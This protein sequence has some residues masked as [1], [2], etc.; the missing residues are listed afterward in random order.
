MT[1]LD[2]R[3]AAIARMVRPGARTA[4]IGT[5]HGYLIAYLAKENIIPGGFAC[6][7]RPQPL[8]KARGL[9]RGQGL[10]SRVKVLLT[11]GLSGLPRDGVDD[12]VIAGMGGDTMIHI[13]S[14][15]G[16]KDP[17][18]R[19]LL[20][21]M[22]RASQLRQYLCREGYEILEEQAAEAGGFVYAILR[23]AFTGNRWEPDELFCAFGLMPDC[24]GRESLQYLIRQRE[25]LSARLDGLCR[26][27]GPDAGRI[28][29]ARELLARMDAV[30]SKKEGSAS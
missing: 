10:L 1:A 2:P 24:P 14:Q 22:T 9:L 12:V 27:A 3:L 20:Q 18:K 29:E 23:A 17:E 21:P 28:R 30:I 15:A 19:F 16:W 25:A 8:E 4:D 11:D 6:D 7:I 5:D 26:A 13:L